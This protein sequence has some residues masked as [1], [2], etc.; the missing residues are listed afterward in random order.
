MNMGTRK[1]TVAASVTGAMLLVTA[2]TLL[3]ANAAHG[4]ASPHVPSAPAGLVSPCGGTVSTTLSASSIRTCDPVTITT[5]TA[6]SCPVC[7]GGMNVVFQMPILVPV[8]HW[9][10]DEAS[11]ALDQMAEYQKPG[12]PTIQV[13]VTEYGIKVAGGGVRRTLLDLTEDLDKARPFFRNRGSSGGYGYGTDA[14][15]PIKVLKKARGKDPAAKPCEYDVSFAMACNYIYNPNDTGCRAAQQNLLAAAGR[16]RGEGITLLEA[17]PGRPVGDWGECRSVEPQMTSADLYEKY[18]QT[19]LRAMVK[20]LFDEGT[21]Q[22]PLKGQTLTEFLPPGLSYVPGSA[23]EPPAQVSMV[24]DRTMLRWNWQLA[25]ASEAH[26]VTFRAQPVQEGQW[27]I[28]GTLGIVDPR[29]LQRQV[30]MQPVTVTVAGLCETPTPPATPSATPPPTPTASATPVRLTPAKPTGTPLPS[31]TPT[32]TATRRPA[33]V[34]LPL[35]LREQCVPGQKRIDVA[36]VIDASTSMLEPTAAGPTKLDTAR[37]AVRTFLDQLHLDAGD[38]AAIIVFNAEATVLQTLT[39]NRTAL[40]QALDRIQTAQQTRIHRGIEEATTELT[41]SRHRSG[42]VPAMI[43]LTDGRA[44]PDSPELAVEAGRAATALG[45]SVF[46]V[47]LGNEVDFDALERMASQPSYF[48]RAPKAED[49][50]GIYREIA[51]VIPCPPEAFWGR[52]P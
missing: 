51:R 49:L 1:R 17:C 37:A 9:L 20:R 16:F 40:G 44:N 11:G 28:T 26:T 50:E 32:A 52:R 27:P 5:R 39:A 3:G 47:G 43:V 7:A 46:T 33:P 22:Q 15:E 4:P 10:E 30:P 38:Q 12:A 13:A 45:I 31:A 34:Y 6:P 23:S 8:I 18:P 35:T 29:N 24:A 21:G 36:L 19:K 41:S 48:Y 2:L 42:N 14:D 25:A